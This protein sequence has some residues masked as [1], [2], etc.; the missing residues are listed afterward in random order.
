MEPHPGKIDFNGAGLRHKLFVY[1]KFKTLYFEVIIAFFRLIQ[2]HGKGRT[3]SAAGVQKNPN[4]SRLFPLKIV[5]DLRFRSISQLNHLTL[6][7]SYLMVR[8]LA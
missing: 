2:S 7:L 8:F 1:D 4:G 6:S 5:I 3:A